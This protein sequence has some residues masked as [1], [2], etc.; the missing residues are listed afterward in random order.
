[1]RTR[2][3]SSMPSSSTRP[4]LRRT[5]KWRL[6]RG[7]RPLVALAGAADHDHPLAIFK[8]GMFD[9]A[10]LAF[11][12][13]ADG[14]TESFDEPVDGARRILVIDR[15]RNARPTFRRWSHGSFST[16]VCS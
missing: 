3:S 2:A 16:Y 1:M 5:R 12:L 11:H 4:D 13:Q 14:E 10:A 7:V 6:M 15:T 8:L 9:A